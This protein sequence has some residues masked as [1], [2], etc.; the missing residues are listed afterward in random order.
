MSD[1]NS[2]DIVEIILM[3]CLANG[4]P[5]DAA[6]AIEES[7]R[8][9]YGGLRVRIP[10]RKKHPSA[11]QR[12]GAFEDGLTGMSTEDVTTRHNISRATL[13]RLMKSP[14]LK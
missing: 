14:E 2:P 12:K 13:Y 6:K 7:V 5:A 9:D 10:K 3:A 4:L 1:D 8:Q 11:L